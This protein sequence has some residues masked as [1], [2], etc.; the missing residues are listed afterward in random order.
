[1][2]EPSRTNLDPYA[3]LEVGRLFGLTFA[4][5]FRNFLPLTVV[6]VLVSLPQTIWTV[7]HVRGLTL[8]D[9]EAQ[10]AGQ[11]TSASQWVVTIVS[12]ALTSIG[13]GAAIYL[14][15]RY[16][17]ARERASLRRS[18]AVAF[19]VLPSLLAI[20]LLLGL[21]YVVVL[22]FLAPL[23]GPSG[24]LGVLLLLGFLA[25]SLALFVAFCVCVPAALLERLGPI[26]ALRRSWQ[27]TSGHRWRICGLWLLL[28]AVSLGLAIVLMAFAMMGGAA[29]DP[30]Q[31]IRVTTYGGLVL[32]PILWGLAVVLI[33]VVYFEL[34]RLKEGTAPEE[35]GTVFE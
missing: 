18:L 28:G 16:L 15:S 9:L 3:R 30:F 14:L 6:L 5:Y 13:T 19:G 27:L 31:M 35:L 2:T 20:G 23:L 33:A 4:T 34:R 11:V 10:A 26:D 8:E 21:P 22:Q 12:F 32:G 1:M 7:V 17:Q 29:T 25:V 24:G